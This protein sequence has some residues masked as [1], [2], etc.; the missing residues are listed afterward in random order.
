MAQTRCFAHLAAVTI[1]PTVLRPLPRAKPTPAILNSQFRKSTQNQPP[2]HHPAVME[3]SRQGAASG[4]VC[5]KIR[6]TPRLDG[7]TG[8]RSGLKT[9]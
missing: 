8:R 4:A 6:P 1:L 2:T 9:R 3:R 5:A 7:G